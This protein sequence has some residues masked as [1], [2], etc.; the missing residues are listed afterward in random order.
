MC[1]TTFSVDSTMRIVISRTGIDNI[2]KRVVVLSNEVAV[3]YVI[4]WGSWAQLF[5]A[6]LS[7]RP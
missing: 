5:S 2:T 1:S 7:E 3:S 4:S 6:V